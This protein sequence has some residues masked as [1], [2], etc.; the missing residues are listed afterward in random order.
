MKILEFL[1]EAVIKEGGDGSALWVCKAYKLEQ[2]FDEIFLFNIINHT[3][4]N[5]KLEENCLVWGENQES[6]TIFFSD[7]EYACSEFYEIKVFY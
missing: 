7:I 5:L 4:W 3:G 6:V 2:V 1:Y